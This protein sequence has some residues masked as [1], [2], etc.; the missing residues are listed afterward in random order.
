[1]ENY[2]SGWVVNIQNRAEFDTARYFF[3]TFILNDQVGHFE[4]MFNVY[5]RKHHVNRT[6][7]FNLYDILMHSELIPEYNEMS[8]LEIQSINTH[9][10]N[11]SIILSKTIRQYLERPIGQCSHYRTDTDRPFNATSYVQCYR[12]CL[13]S[14]A[15]KHLNCSPLLIHSSLNGMDF[16][17]S[18][19]NLCGFVKT[20]EYLNKLNS[21]DWSARCKHTCPQ[22]CLSIGYYSTIQSTDTK[23]GNE[24]WHK[25]AESERYYRRSVVWD[26]T[27]PMFVYRE[28]SVLSFTDFLCYCSGLLGLWFGTNASD[29]IKLVIDLNIWNKIHNYIYYG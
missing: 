4:Q 23:I 7:D 8:T 24:L 11:Y 28:E 20:R 25:L 19:D 14:Y 15:I 6:I 2:I 12:L 22:D 18:G 10:H 21:L 26:S 13:K 27:Q 9:S 16:D 1:M 17:K 5:I 3:V 29:L